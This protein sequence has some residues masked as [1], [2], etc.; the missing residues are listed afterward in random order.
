MKYVAAYFLTGNLPKRHTICQPVVPV[1]N[2]VG[3]N[4]Q[5]KEKISLETDGMQAPLMA[6]LSVEDARIFEA[7]MELVNLPEIVPRLGM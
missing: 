2:G 4:N 3:I 1:F 7:L 6:S 5:N